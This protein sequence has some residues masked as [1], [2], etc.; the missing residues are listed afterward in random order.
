MKFLKLTL[1]CALCNI[2]HSP[3]VIAQQ[4]PDQIFVNGNI[5]TVDDSFSSQQVVAVAGERILA[6]G[7]NEAIETLAGP[8]T[9]TTDLGEQTVIPGLI[10]NH[11]HVVRATEYW[12][13]EALLDGVTSRARALELL[14]A[15]ADALPGGECL[16][17]LGGWTESQFIGSHADFTLAKLDAIAPGRPTFLQSVYNHA[18]GNTAWLQAM[19]IPLPASAREQSAATGLASYIV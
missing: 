6:V 3:W 19:G 18:F 15:K 10:A 17:T 5:V 14:E 1:V 9:R 4:A 12:P 8:E 7:T 2:G 16:M 11:N 13:N